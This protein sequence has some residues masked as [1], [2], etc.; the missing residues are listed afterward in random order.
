MVFNLRQLKIQERHPVATYYCCRSAI[1]AMTAHA[2]VRAGAEVCMRV[3]VC[4]CG[5]KDATYP[6]NQFVV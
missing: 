2:G 3:S 4:M 1:E 5:G 6:N